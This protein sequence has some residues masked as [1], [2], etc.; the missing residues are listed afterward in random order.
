[1]CVK[2]MRVRVFLS[3]IGKTHEVLGMRD[4]SLGLNSD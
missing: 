1:M 4:S 2:P 3:G